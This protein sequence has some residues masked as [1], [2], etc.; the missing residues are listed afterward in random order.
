[1]GQPARHNK[2]IRHVRLYHYLL[3]SPAWQE[4]S[5]NA[6]SIYIEISRRYAGD[7]SNNGNIP[8]SVREAA[9]S[10]RI[11]KSTAGRAIEELQKN[12]FIVM[13]KPGAFSLKTRHATEWRLTEFPCDVTG[14]SATKD[15][16]RWSLQK[17]NSVPLAGL[18]VPVVGPNGTCGGTERS[19]TRLTVPVVGP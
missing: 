16:M 4:L 2:V 10:L 1:M 5:A 11:G 15:F 7:G 14:Q 17:Q 13:A 8:Y 3:K 6:R 12:G 18:T 19:I 9:A